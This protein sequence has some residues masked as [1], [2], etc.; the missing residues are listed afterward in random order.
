IAIGTIV[1]MGIVVCENILKH[2]DRADPGES[3][4][5]IVHRATVEVGGAVLTAVTTTVL[6][7]LAVFAMEGP[8]GKLFRP[9]AFTKTFALVAS[10]V[11]ALALI[12]PLAH[13]LLGRGAGMAPR[14]ARF[15]RLPEAWR[16]RL[17]R[18]R[19]FAIAGVVLILLAGDWMPLG[20]EKGIANHAFVV[21][22]VTGLLACFGGFIRVYDRALAW[23]LDRKAILLAGAA[24]L[25]TLGFLAWLGVATVFAFVPDRLRDN[26]LWSA[27]TDTFPGLGREFMPPLDE[28]SF[29]F[30]PSLMPHA[31][32]GEATDVLSLQ[33]RAIRAIPEV[34]S[35]VGKIGRADSPLDPAPVSMI[36]T[37]VN[38]KPEYATDSE[39][40]RHRQWRDEIRTPDD[41]WREILR[42]TEL[43]G[44]TSAPRLQPIETRLV[45]LQTGMRAPMGLKVRGPDLE[46]IERAGLEIERVLREVPA[47]EPASVFADRIV[48]KPYLEI[49][50]DRRAIGRYGMTIQSVQDIIEVA[51]GGRRVTTTVEG[52]ER[53]A[54]RVRYQRELRDTLESLGGILIPARDGTQVPL[55]QLAEIRYERGPQAIKS[56]DTFLT[57]YVIFDKKP[58]HAEV[59]VVRQAGMLL[60]DRLDSGAL[61]LPAGVTYR[62]TGSHENQVRASEKLRLLVPV[63]LLLIFIVI[64][65]Q[66]KSVTTTA[67]VF[68]GIFVA[69][70]GGFLL[71]WLYGQ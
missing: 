48:G 32:I 21:L 3:R 29:L 47:I 39:G 64:Y 65:L 41:I 40:R 67:L 7:F 31:S 63:S 22:L 56:E 33:D 50:I 42:V 68:S 4:L 9:L 24:A 54:V 6:S 8:E 17:P 36:E 58:G 13:L 11:V 45:M 71:L 5:E 23:I 26:A 27:A 62:F 70:S 14:R 60:G 57:G 46:S 51:I 1:D 66:F 59:E 49:D 43:P 44:V 10:I 53:Y 35:V 34:D 20:P 12:P 28:G 18:V 16:S 69:W 37:I 38:Y 52:R 15:D 19:S 30:M 25:V 61:V 2:L 55:R